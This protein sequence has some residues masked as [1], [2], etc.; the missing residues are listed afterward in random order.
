MSPRSY[1]SGRGDLRHV[2]SSYQSDHKSCT[3]FLIPASLYS[4]GPIPDRLFPEDPHGLSSTQPSPLSS[5]PA[6]TASKLTLCGSANSAQHLGTCTR[7]V[8]QQALKRTH[9]SHPLLSQVD[10]E[11]AFPEP[12]DRS[13]PTHSIIYWGYN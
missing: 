10:P 2:G 12:S 13:H 6:V 7:Y 8:N 1:D 9:F 4:T 11:Q 3:F 5:T